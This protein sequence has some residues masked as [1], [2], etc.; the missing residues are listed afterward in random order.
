MHELSIALKIVEIAEEEAARRGG[1]GVHA[2][3]LRL[4]PLAGVVKEALESSYEL[5][6]ENSAVAGSRLV[7]EEVPVVVFCPKCQ[8]QRKLSSMQWFCCPECNTPTGE[9]V[10][11]RELEVVALELEE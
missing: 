1:A 7:I 9:I 11:G 8:A 3:H 5:A 10:H 2:V 6:R 4:G